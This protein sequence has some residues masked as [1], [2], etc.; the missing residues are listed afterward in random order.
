MYLMIPPPVYTNSYDYDRNSFNMKVNNE[1]LSRLIWTIAKD[2]RFHDQQVINLFESM[3]G[4]LRSEY[5]LF[6]DGES[7]DRIH[8]NSAGYSL[9]ASMVFGALF[10][11]SMKV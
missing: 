5:E 1:V 11:P 4:H 9:I 10:G 2:L 8:P 7:C 6:C 3:G